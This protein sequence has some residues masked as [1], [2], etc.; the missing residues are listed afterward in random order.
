LS[1]FPW[2]SFAQFT[3]NQQLAYQEIL[4]LNLK[5]AEKL[6]E[7]EQK[8]QSTS[9]TSVS[10]QIIQNINIYLQNYI[11]ILQLLAFQHDS[12]YQLS[13][14]EEDNNLEKIGKTD[15]KSP[16]H[17]FLQA[18][19]KIQWALVKLMFG[20]NLSAAW[21]IKQAYHLLTE[22]QR[23]HPYFLPNKKSL[24]LLHLALGSVPEK[25]QWLLQLVG[26]E[27]DTAQG[28][29]EM[30]AV[31][32]G[33]TEFE[34]ETQLLLML[35]QAY[36]LNEPESALA[37]IQ[38][39]KADNN[40]LQVR[41]LDSILFEFIYN[42]VSIKAGKLVIN[43]NT[44]SKE[45]QDDNFINHTNNQYLHSPL[46][47]YLEGEMFLL[48]GNYAQAITSYQL[49]L[50]HFKGK[51]YIKSAYYRLFLA[52][53]LHNA[54]NATHYLDLC[55]KNGHTQMEADKSAENFASNYLK[56]KQL[57][58]K[59]LM[60]ARLLTDG[61]DYARAWGVTQQME[62]KDLDNQKDRIE[63]RYRKARIL[64]KQKNYPAAIDFYKQTISL[65]GSLPYYFAPNAALHL[66]YLY[67]DIFKDNILAISYFKK[68]LTYEKHEY[69]G[70]LHQKAKMRLKK[71]NKRK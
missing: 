58:N 44:K 30:Q 11:I 39:A 6:I 2:A 65:S 56:T 29:K 50:K 16:Y 10:S 13:K 7:K 34:W 38:V 14:S 48:S 57:P 27:G 49:F 59:K 62:E 66:G 68:V 12:L 54:S 15:K 1:I 31:I 60:Q 46:F 40:S 55:L 28:L 33:N 35:A 32:A 23:L 19:I 43:K 47:D 37:G 3:P 69:S 70:S 42:L 20:E 36:I 22:N 25:Y 24:G 61:G 51:N 52:A 4:N 53:W 41:N 45:T 21:S 9:P 5:N 17:R 18:E 8:N 67:H 26:L 64:D 63:L 71:L